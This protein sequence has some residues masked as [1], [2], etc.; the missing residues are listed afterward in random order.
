MQLDSVVIASDDLERGRHAYARLLGVESMSLPGD[1]HRFQFGR[2][3][4]EIVAGATGL[5]A[6]RFIAS[7]SRPTGELFHGLRVLVETSDDEG[8]AAALAAQSRPAQ[9]AG[10]VEAIDHVVVRTA[11]PGRAI[12]LWR[13][14]YGLRLALD[15]EF[16][17]RGLRLQFFRSA[18]MTLEYASPIPPPSQARDDDTLYGVSYRVADLALWRARLV[19]QGVDV[20]EVRPGMKPGTLVAS[21]R[22]GTE[23]IPTLLIQAAAPESRP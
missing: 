2:G 11:D 15:R 3:A 10:A 20:S 12:A 14:R 17:A 13:D 1:R 18:G 6:L 23:G 8:R 19:E 21:V 7:G 22:S 4:V 5:Q 16:P 9:P